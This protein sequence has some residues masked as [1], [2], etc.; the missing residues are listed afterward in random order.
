MSGMKGPFFTLALIIFTFIHCSFCVEADPMADMM[1]LMSQMMDTALD[2]STNCANISNTILNG[3]DKESQRIVSTAQK[4]DDMGLEIGYMSDK[5]IYVD[6]TLANLTSE[7]FCKGF[8]SNTSN[9]WNK[10]TQALSKNIHISYEI[11]HDND[12]DTN[13]NK[14]ILPERA[15][16]HRVLSDWDPLFDAMNRALTLMDEVATSTTSTMNNEVIA[17]GSMSD[18]IL[19]MEDQIMVMAKQIGVMA[20]RISTTVDMMSSAAETCCPKF[21]LTPS[22]SS[23]ANKKTEGQSSKDLKRNNN[24]KALHLPSAPDVIYTFQD[25][26]VQLASI[27]GNDECR[28]DPFCWAS[29]TM[30]VMIDTMTQG[31]ASL[32]IDFDKEVDQGTKKILDYSNNILDDAAFI[33]SLGELIGHMA[34]CIVD[35]EKY[36]ADMFSSYCPAGKMSFAYSPKH[37][38]RKLEGT[39]CHAISPVSPIS[40]DGGTTTA[41]DKSTSIISRIQHLKEVKMKQMLFAE[42][43][44]AMHAQTQSNNSSFSTRSELSGE[45]GDFT[46]M[47][48]LCTQMCSTVTSM[49]MDMMYIAGDTGASIA[50][51]IGQIGDMVGKINQMVVQINAMIGR[52]NQLTADLTELEKKCASL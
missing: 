47:V 49:S 16:M 30:A 19:N 38:D 17:I 9:H 40:S 12:M 29:K 27:G 41:I 15:P 34:D 4:I 26:R 46:A 44:G 50:K 45:F 24:I 10:S 22:M 25:A 13:I 21:D 20:D 14:V 36:G 1:L 35:I 51:M 37:F 32:M 48:D 31:L 8:E 5:I 39:L 11:V 28:L 42:H 33:N 52:I 2:L 6:S 43:A 18:Q 3:I 23:I 7:C